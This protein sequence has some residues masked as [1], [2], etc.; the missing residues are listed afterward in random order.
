MAADTRTD[1]A[2]ELNPFCN[3]TKALEQF[4]MPGMSTNAFVDARRKDIEALVAANKVAFEALQALAVTQSDMLTEAMQS[5]KESA[6]GAMADNTDGGD[7]TKHAEAAQQA[8]RKMLTD[9]K[10]LAETVQKAQFEAVS[11]LTE[12]ARASIGEMTGLAYRT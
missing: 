7:M 4:K 2:S 10:Q 1:N 5:M 8:W 3:L 12:R 9:M 11:G 6:K